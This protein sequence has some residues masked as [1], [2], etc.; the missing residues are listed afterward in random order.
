MPAQA[1][2]LRASGRIFITIRGA[3]RSKK[4]IA[5]RQFCADVAFADWLLC[6]HGRYAAIVMGKNT[7]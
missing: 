5:M 3:G 1:K 6:V 2:S 7:P 4:D